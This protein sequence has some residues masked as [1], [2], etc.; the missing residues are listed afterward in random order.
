MA[1][2]FY[3]PNIS[4][5]LFWKNSARVI[6][7]GLLTWLFSWAI[8]GIFTSN[9]MIVGLIILLTLISSTFFFNLLFQNY[10]I[11]GWVFF[12]F[13]L[14]SIQIEN[15]YHIAL[16]LLLIAFGSFSIS[17]ISF[18]LFPYLV[19]EYGLIAIL[20]YLP[21]SLKILIQVLPVLK[22]D[23]SQSIFNNI[24]KAIGLTKAKAKYKRTNNYRLDQHLFYY[25]LIYVQFAVSFF[26]LRATIPW[27]FII[28]I[29]VFSVNKVL[30][31]FLDDQNS[32]MFVLTSAIFHSIQTDNLLILIPFWV[33]A[34]PI[35]ILSGM[36]MFRDKIDQL[37]KVKPIDLSEVEK[38]V[39]NFLSPLN[40]NSKVLFSWNDPGSTYEKIFDG[41]RNLFEILHYKA[42]QRRQIIRPDWWS[43]FELNYEGA[44]DFW[45]R[46][47]DKVS[48]QMK[49]WG[50]GY[51]I[52]YQEDKKELEN[53][54]I[55][56]GFSELSAIHWDF[57]EDD[58]KDYSKLS[59]SKLSWFLLEKK[60]K[61]SP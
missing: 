23:R 39:D 18:F 59:Y 25:L 61:Q 32:R 41:Y 1:R 38:K 58:I 46:D 40:E 14:F 35:P 57:L 9:P 5:S 27:I 37:I 30:F 24:S 15:E 55:D 44:Q 6:F 21:V 11:L 16:A 31:R 34:N 26:L 2:C 7:L 50:L 52:I 42:T 56:S 3:Y 48:N 49:K 22:S 19:M 10:N 28:A 51:S 45:G 47:P 60:S 20:I 53:K 43:I 13:L 33:L 17:I 54:W 4:F 29:G 12:P 8:F 36:D